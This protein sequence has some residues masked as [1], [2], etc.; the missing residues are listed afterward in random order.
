MFAFG[1]VPGT[2]GRRMMTMMISSYTP[3]HLPVPISID[4][5]TFTTTPNCEKAFL[6]GGDNSAGCPSTMMKD[7]L[8]ACNKS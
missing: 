1:I 3:V 8:S 4:V 2:A 6:I 7:K 5:I